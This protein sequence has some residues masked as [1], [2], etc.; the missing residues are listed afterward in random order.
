M[1]LVV[2]Q[3]PLAPLERGDQEEEMEIMEQMA[4]MEKAEDQ[5][6]M[7]CLAPQDQL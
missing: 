3:V 2:H 6:V 7:E 5:V 1:G 4:K